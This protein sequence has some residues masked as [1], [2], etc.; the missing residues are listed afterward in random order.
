MFNKGKDTSEEQMKCPWN[1]S[2]GFAID[3]TFASRLFYFLTRMYKEAAT[4]P[5]GF[6]EEYEYLL[7]GASKLKIWQMGVPSMLNRNYFN[8]LKSIKIDPK[9]IKYLSNINCP[10]AFDVDK[11]L[12]KPEKENN[13]TNNVVCRSDQ[14]YIAVN[15]DGEYRIFEGKPYRRTEKVMVEDTTRWEEDYYGKSCHPY[16][17]NGEYRSYWT[18]PLNGKGAY[19]D[20]ENLPAA[21]QNMDWENEPRSI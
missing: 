21:F 4:L 10:N 19:I 12:T 7:K 6:E 1:S 14:A 18:C 20:K 8:N 5:P 9:L 3:Y 13:E 17:W 2:Y 15:K 16:V 11:Y